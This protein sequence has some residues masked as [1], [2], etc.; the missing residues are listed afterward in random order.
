MN[1]PNLITCD[2][3]AECNQHDGDRIRVVGIY[4][5]YDPYPKNRKFEAKPL[6]QIEL[7][8][9][10]KGPFLEP[11]WHL[12]AERPADEIAQFNGR[13]VCVTGTYYKT[14]PVNPKDPPQAVSFGGSCIHPVETI[15][16]VSS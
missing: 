3:L 4:T 8:N 11:F 9:Q 2:T 1:Q 14:Q 10:E 7:S 15:E 5:L 13:K 16:V 6:V 12:D